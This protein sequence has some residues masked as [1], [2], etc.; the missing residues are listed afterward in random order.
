MQAV[1]FEPTHL[2]I[3]ELESRALNHSA[4]LADEH[5]RPGHH[6]DGYNCLRM[7]VLFLP[8]ALRNNIIFCEHKMFQEIWFWNP[9]C[10]AE[11]K[12]SRIQRK[13]SKK[14]ESVLTEKTFALELI[15]F[16]NFFLK[17]SI[18]PNNFS[19]PLRT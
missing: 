1:G 10:S 16:E 15:H 12:S 11:M 3:R 4:T 17:E 6:P 7:E 19:N 18:P 2:S 9:F 8:A 5:I 13:K 14:N